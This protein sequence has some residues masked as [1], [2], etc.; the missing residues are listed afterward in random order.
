MNTT[1]DLCLGAVFVVFYAAGRFNTPA[2]NRSSTT[3]IRY[4]LG[5]FCYCMVG[6]LGYVAFVKFPHLL[7]FLMQGDETVVQPWATK[8]SS[9]LLAALLLTV[10]L[11]RLPLLS[12]LD[13]WIRKQ[14]QDMAAIPFEVRRLSAELRKGKLEV[15]DAMQGEVIKILERRGILRKNIS[16]QADDTPAYY[17]ARIAV[18]LTEAR[19]WE[20][21]RKMSSYLAALPGELDQLWKR[22]DQLL[23]K[24]KTY[25]RLQNEG[26]E[27]LTARTH[28]AMVRYQ[29]D[30]TEQLAQLHTSV[31]DFISRGVLHAE[32]TDG[33]RQE[34]LEQ[35][36][37]QAQWRRTRFTFDQATFVFGVLLLVMLGSMLVFSSATST[38]TFGTRLVRMAVNAIIYCVAA[39]CAVV[40]KERWKFARHN[41]G[42]VRPVGFYI[43]SGLLAVGLGMFFKFLS[44][45]LLMG[46]VDQAVQHFLLRYPW[47]LTIFATTV[48]LGILLD[49]QQSARLSKMQQRIFEAVAQGAVMAGISYVS[50]LWLAE[51][52]PH[53][54]PLV[55]NLSV[56]DL[57]RTMTTAG[58]IGL[59]LGFWVPAWYRET[60]RT[61]D[62]LEEVEPALNLAAPQ[63]R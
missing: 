52:A 38:A 53:A 55:A 39:A 60:P 4:F 6:L 61:N 34:R 30:F 43:V 51:R 59:V 18:L 49:N 21:D 31:L 44:N 29:E 58:I 14:L 32:L 20:S 23:V 27:G 41:P 47:F 22:L 40:P 7:A 25:F 8:L 37:F 50:W 15:D 28:E 42:H 17:C 5:L 19:D 11:P 12:D 10:L 48:M 57:T 2:T 24:A 1:V 35:M 45:C 3:A 46:N 26:M 36:G 13:N 54:G 62:E 16:F 33:T 63:V 56:P 9:P